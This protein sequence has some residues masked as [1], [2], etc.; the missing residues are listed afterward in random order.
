MIDTST[1][2]VTE[3]GRVERKSPSPVRAPQQQ[4]REKKMEE[5][6]VASTAAARP[7]PSMPPIAPA[8]RPIAKHH[9]ASFREHFENKGVHFGERKHTTA[10]P[11]TYTYH[12]HATYA[13]SQSNS[14][15]NRNGWAK[16]F[17]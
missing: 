16:R 12:G 7:R 6:A 1:R 15:A 3:L 8:S 5:P 10:A 2:P 4:Q 13:P 11:S 9:S 17:K 14:G